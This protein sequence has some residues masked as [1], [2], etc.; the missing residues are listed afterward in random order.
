MARAII[1]IAKSGDEADH[2]LSELMASHFSNN[3]I[4][5]LFPDKTGF[6]DMGHE[7]HSKAPEGAAAGAGTGG[8]VGG[9]VGLLVG[10]GMVA[11]PGLGPFLAA[12]PIMAA[13]SGAAVGATVGGVAGILVGLGIP[14]IEARQYEGRLKDGNILISVHSESAVEQERVRRIFD[15]GGAGS[16]STTSETPV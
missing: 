14:E 6:R 7:R 4:S 13:L 1:C 5:I 9:A 2:I 11:I 12:G 16:I 10:M 15:K 3:D 8:L